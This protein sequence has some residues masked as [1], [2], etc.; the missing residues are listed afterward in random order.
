MATTQELLDQAQCLVCANATDLF[1]TLEIGILRNILSELGAPMT[2]Q[3]INTASNCFLC[4]GMSLAEANILVLLNAMSGAIAGGV[5]GGG[6][7]GASN[8]EGSVT[9]EPGTLYFNTANATFW[10]KASGSGDTGWQQ[11]I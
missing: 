11:L 8:P 7:V 4:Y 9:A 10:V 2:Q 6:E 3:E 5:G 1:Q